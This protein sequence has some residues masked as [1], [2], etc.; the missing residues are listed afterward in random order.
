MAAQRELAARLAKTTAIPCTC[1]P[2]MCVFCSFSEQQY[3]TAHVCYTSVQ[4]V[5][6][7]NEAL[8]FQDYILKAI[9]LK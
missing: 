5:L 8:L 3:L 6:L 4:V 9:K 1:T 7:I 2:K